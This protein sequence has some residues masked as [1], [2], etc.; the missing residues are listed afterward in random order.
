MKHLTIRIHAIAVDG[1]PDA[2]MEPGRVA[3]IYDGCILTGWPLIP[4]RLR[5]EGSGV[6]PLVAD[7]H[8]AGDTLWEA[9]SDTGRAQPFGGVTHWVE[10][11]ESLYD[12][13]AEETA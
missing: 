10:F 3:F 1:L 5:A 12:L 7:Y 13:S 11:P 4:D 9:E 2:D 6:G 8:A